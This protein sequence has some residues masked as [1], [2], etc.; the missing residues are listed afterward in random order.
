MISQTVDTN[1]STKEK[2]EIAITYVNELVKNHGSVES[3]LMSG[4][5]IRGN[6]LA[7]SDVDI[8]VVGRKKADLPEIKKGVYNGIFM[9]IELYD[10]DWLFYTSSS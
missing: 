8:W 9:D 4:S 1:K 10:W 2:R 5:I 3:V 6:D 7:I